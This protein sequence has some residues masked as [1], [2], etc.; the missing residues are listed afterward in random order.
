M[1]GGRRYNRMVPERLKR[2]DTVYQQRPI[3]FITA[4]SAE[5]R[6]LLADPVIHDAFRSLAETGAEMGAWIGAYILMPD[7]LH[8]FVVADAE[9]L[10]L[11][12][13]IKSLKGTLS[14]ELRRNQSSTPFWQKGFF[15]HVLRSHDSYSAKWSYMRENAVRAGPAANWEDWPYLGEIFPISFRDDRS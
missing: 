4:C 3:Y 2:L 7:H 1:V 6:K 11:S 5:R 12:S 9:R 8:L 10:N 14:L 13:W 15:D